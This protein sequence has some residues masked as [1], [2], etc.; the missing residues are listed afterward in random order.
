MLGHTPHAPSVATV[1]SHGGFEA[2]LW[3]ALRGP[4]RR[5]RNGGRLPY[6]A[7][8]AFAAPD[9]MM[10]YPPMAFRRISPVDLVLYPAIC[11]P[12]ARRE[13]RPAFQTATQVE[14]SVSVRREV[15]MP[16]AVT[17]QS[18]QSGSAWALGFEVRRALLPPRRSS[19][20]GSSA[21]VG[22]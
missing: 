15:G 1:Q 8:K 18:D 9:I 16:V 4:V 22:T 14:R 11:S 12:V 13:A 21:L 7:S 3:R 10:I 5:L 20:G 6:L 17:A 19:L 2:G